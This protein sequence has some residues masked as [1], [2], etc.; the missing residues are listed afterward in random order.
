VT[1][2]IGDDREGKFLIVKDLNSAQWLFFLNPIGQI[3][4]IRA[5]A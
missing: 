5:E 1:L 2:R 3:P 4:E